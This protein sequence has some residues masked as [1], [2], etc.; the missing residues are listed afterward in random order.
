MFNEWANPD[1]GVVAPIIG[2]TG[3]PKVEAG[4]EDQ[5]IGLHCELLDAAEERA[6]VD[7]ERRSL[8]DANTRVG[9]H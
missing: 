6:T 4:N 8:D 5:A 7:R 9:F 3:L 1:N 2:R